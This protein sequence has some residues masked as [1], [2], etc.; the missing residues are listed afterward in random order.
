MIYSASVIKALQAFHLFGTSMQYHP[1]RRRMAAKKLALLVFLLGL[2]LPWTSG[3]A[4]GAPRLSAY[5]PVPGLAP[6]PYYG[7]RVR[8][9]SLFFFVV[10]KRFITIISKSCRDYGHHHNHYRHQ[11]KKNLDQM[12]IIR[13]VKRD[14]KSCFHC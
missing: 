3:L 8:E 1:Q 9:V 4:L 12:I 7:L 10:G 14:G 6:S 13:L 5:P 2:A 11:G